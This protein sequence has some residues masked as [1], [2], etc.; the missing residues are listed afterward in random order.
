MGHRHFRMGPSLRLGLAG[1]ADRDS[2]S[3]SG[4]RGSSSRRGGRPPAGPGAGPQAGAII[5]DCPRGAIGS[6]GAR[7]KFPANPRT[8]AAA[9]SRDPK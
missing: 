3:D 4:P 5:R 2:E 6:D 9:K 7:A 1:D 8:Q